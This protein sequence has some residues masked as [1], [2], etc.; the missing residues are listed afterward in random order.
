MS[1]KYSGRIHDPN[2]VMA[3]YDLYF[4]DTLIVA[5]YRNYADNADIVQGSLNPQ[6]GGNLNSTTRVRTNNYIP[7]TAGRYK[8]ITEASDNAVLY[9]YNSS[10]EWIE[11]ASFTE[12]SP[13]GSIYDITNPD[14]AYIRL[15]FAKIQG[16]TITPEEVTGIMIMEV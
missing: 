12:W 10:K 9:A 13:S 4:N 16:G 5:Y 2:H 1:K 6:S 7:I 14:V 11:S 15:A 8:V 3:E